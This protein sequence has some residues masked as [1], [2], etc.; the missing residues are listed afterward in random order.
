MPME[1]WLEWARGPVFWAA[2]TFMVLG[3]VRHVV[4]TVWEIARI[5]RR[6]GTRRIPY[7][8]VLA[9]TLQVAG[10]GRPIEEPAGSS[11]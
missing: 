5:M 11:A 10:P 9:A 4:L 6:A 1:A 3:L 8:Q 7:R 2:L